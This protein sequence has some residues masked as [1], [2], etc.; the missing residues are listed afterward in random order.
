[1]IAADALGVPNT[2]MRISGNVNGGDWKFHDYFLSVDRPAYAP[3]TPQVNL[4]HH[5]DG[6]TCAGASIIAQRQ[7][8]LQTAFKKTGL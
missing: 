7:Q 1:M 2:W 4:K 8:E 3:V 6:I 5:E